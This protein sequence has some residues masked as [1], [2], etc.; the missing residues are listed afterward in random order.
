[1][2]YMI[3]A[4]DTAGLLVTEARRRQLAPALATLNA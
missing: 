2:N 1:M 4:C 3:V